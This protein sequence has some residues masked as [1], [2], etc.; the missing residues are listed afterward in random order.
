MP[1][2]AHGTDGEWDLSGVKLSLNPNG[3]NRTTVQHY[4][5]PPYNP[6]AKVFA[7]REYLR[8]T[9]LIHAHRYCKVIYSAHDNLSLSN[10]T[11]PGQSNSLNVTTRWYLNTT[12]IMYDEAKIV[13]PKQ[14]FNTIRQCMYKLDKNFTLSSPSLRNFYLPGF[15]TNPP[16]LL[17]YILYLYEVI[18]DPTLKDHRVNRGYT[19]AAVH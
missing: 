11:S 18:M 13:N 1:S 7:D 14:P 12:R 4:H 9:V 5:L 19:I 10:Q 17:Y 8:T 3:R 6:S 2:H 15:K 16:Q